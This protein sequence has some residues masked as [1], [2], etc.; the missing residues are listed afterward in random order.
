MKIFVPIVLA[1]AAAQGRE[2]SPVHRPRDPWVFRSVL[3]GH[4]R[5]VTIALSDEMWIA[6]DT[7][8]CGLYKAWKGGVNFDGPVYTTVHG[9]QPTT[10]GKTYVPGVDDEI[11]AASVGGADVSVLVAWRG[12]LFNGDHVALEYE[13]LLPDGRKVS[14]QESPEFVVPEQM[15]DEARLEEL[16][17]T[18]GHP[19][20]LRSFRAIDLPDGVKISV[21]LRTDGVTGKLGET[22][23]RER[24]VD[25]KD[26]KGEMHTQILSHLA[27]SK[28]RPLSNLILFFEPI[29]ALPDAKKDEKG[30]GK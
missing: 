29:P 7:T 17:L 13:I 19:G 14:V 8:T 5:M 18:K 24:F 26:E 28:E 1:F 15:F 10:V 27:L 25:V 12:Y 20:L 3:D 22:L 4:P 6:Y 9:P 30:G 11:W 21:L 23:E 16:V 2:L